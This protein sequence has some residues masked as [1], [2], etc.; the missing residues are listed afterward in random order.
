VSSDP[1]LFNRLDRDYLLERPS[2]TGLPGLGLLVPR[3][4]SP[5][6]KAD[7]QAYWQ[8]RSGP[9]LVVQR[10]APLIRRLDYEL[11]LPA[12]SL[13]GA[14]LLVA[15]ALAELLASAVERQLLG[16]IRPLRGQ[17][18]AG[19]LPD[20]GGSIIRELQVLVELVKLVN[21]RNRPSVSSARRCS[22]PAMSWPRPPWPSRRP[23]RL[24]PTPWCCAPGRSWPSSRS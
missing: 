4:L 8:V 7:A 16:V 5:V 14:L 9:V 2:R 12:F 19:Q 21:R 23:S 20:L 11:L 13:I 6:L 18:N 1:Q 3:R 10:A 24:A 15:A 17:P 22:R